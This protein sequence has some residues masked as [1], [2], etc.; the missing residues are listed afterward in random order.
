V[1]AA[2][3]DQRQEDVHSGTATVRVEVGTGPK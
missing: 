1:D 2:G 3:Q